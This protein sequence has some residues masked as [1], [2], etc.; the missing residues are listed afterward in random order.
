[1][2]AKAGSFYVMPAQAGIQKITASH[3]KLGASL[4][5]H[6]SEEDVSTG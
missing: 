4:R 5:W 6:D 2:L 1:M 3:K